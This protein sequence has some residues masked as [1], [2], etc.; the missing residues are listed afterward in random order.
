MTWAFP[1]NLKRNDYKNAISQ[2]LF[3]RKIRLG[4]I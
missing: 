2:N 3:N 1:E 4:F